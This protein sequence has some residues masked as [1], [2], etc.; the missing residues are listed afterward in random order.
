MRHTGIQEVP[1]YIPIGILLSNRS[2]NSKNKVEH[3]SNVQEYTRG[4]CKCTRSH[5]DTFFEG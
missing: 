4:I 1:V 2:H 5:V 3:G